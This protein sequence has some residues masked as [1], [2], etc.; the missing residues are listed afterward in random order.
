MEIRAQ[1][2]WLKTHRNMLSL[3]LLFLLIALGVFTVV[4]TKDN[5]THLAAQELEVLSQN[6][7]KYYQN[8]PDYWGLHSKVV[9]DKE[10]APLSMIQNN[11]LI[12]RLKNKILVGNGV[13]ADVLMPGARG[14]DIVYKDLSKKHCISLASFDFSKQF[15]FGVA[16]VNIVHGNNSTN[17]SWDDEQNKLPIAKSAAKK[18]CS[19]GGSVIWHFE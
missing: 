4:Q 12:G 8:R 14:F 5:I 15:W 17:F 19:K 6:I 13:E 16:S 2:L 18:A 3:V 7:R 10:I 1:L 11:E 9:V